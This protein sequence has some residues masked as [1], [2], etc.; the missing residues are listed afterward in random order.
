MLEEL[1]V[2]FPRERWNE[3]S[4]GPL[5]ARLAAEFPSI[6]VRFDCEQADAP[7]V[8][9]S[10]WGRADFDSWSFDCRID[11]LAREPFA[12]CVNDDGGAHR[13]FAL[14]VLNRCQR[15]VDR[16]NRHSQGQLF[17]RI[18]R[19]HRALH[20][21][22]KPLVRADYNHSLDVCQW[23]LRLAPDASAALQIAA[24][25][26][27]IERIASEPDARVEHLA[28]DYQSFKDAHAQKGAAM[29]LDV[30]SAAGVPEAV[31]ARVAELVAVHERQSD[32][33][34]V[35]LLNDADA[36]SF[37]SLNSSG[38]ADYFGAEQT[39]KKVAYTWSRMR[40]GARAKLQSVHLREDVDAMLRDVSGGK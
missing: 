23:A 12:L 10:E 33:E 7:H 25:F 38:Y 11:E 14:H 15:V 28:G 31:A 8:I 22:T 36:L 6:F 29:T 9:A 35:A 2:V 27:D 32:D 39:A 26:H 24:L 20:D 37:F 21:L 17:D 19:R 16:R 40:D 34:E 30:L 4:R 18:L 13:D 3:S 1:T 5:S